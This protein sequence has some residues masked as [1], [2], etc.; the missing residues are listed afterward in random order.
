MRF[1]A[2]SLLNHKVASYP[3]IFFNHV[4]FGD[5]FFCSESNWF[6][7]FSFIHIETCKSILCG[8][9]WWWWCYAM[10]PLFIVFCWYFSQDY[11]LLRNFLLLTEWFLMLFYCINLTLGLLFTISL[12][13]NIKRKKTHKLKTTLVFLFFSMQLIV[14]K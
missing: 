9:W 8:Q 13:L 3:S 2:S 1:T 14:L 11:L 6:A 5:S 12:L 4:D 7:C 10:F